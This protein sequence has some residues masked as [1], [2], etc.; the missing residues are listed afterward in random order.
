MDGDSTLIVK[1]ILQNH[2]VFSSP[3]FRKETKKH[4]M[5]VCYCMKKGRLVKCGELGDCSFAK[6]ILNL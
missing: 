4:I 2:I 1:K 6:F 5:D 3:C